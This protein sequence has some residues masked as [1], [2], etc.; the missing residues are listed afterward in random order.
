MK[1]LYFTTEDLN[2]GLFH[3][4]VFG[5]LKAVRESQ[6]KF[7]ITILVINQP[8]K[9]KSHINVLELLKKECI[10]VIYIPLLPPM[11]WFTS[12]FFISNI[13]LIYLTT[14]SYLF[15]NLKKY[16][17]IHCRHYLTSLV[18]IKLRYNNFLFDVR[19]L[20][21]FEYIQAKKI[22]INSATYNYWLNF[23]RLI[24][25]N[26]AAV[27]VVSKTM[28]PYFESIHKRKY[29]FCPII[30]D[31]N[32]IKYCLSSRLLIRNQLKWNDKR[33]YVY[34]GSFGLYGLNKE[35][36]AKMVNFII[37][38][39]INSRF[40][41]LVSN[42]KNEVEHFLSV[43]NFD[44][45]IFHIK[46]TSYSNMY[47]YL[48]AAD[49]GIHSLPNQIDGFSRLGTKIIEYWASGLPVIINNNIGEAA[50]IC[51]EHN[52]GEV[53]NF[54]LNQGDF[55]LILTELNKSDR[56]KIIIDSE[57]LFSSYCIAQKYINIYTN[58][59]ENK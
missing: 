39:D 11:R 41:F 43:N 3:S 38:Y 52:F 47:R 5:L 21:V 22:K 33:I 36:L 26:A 50:R 32:V 49:I 46:N 27:S 14:I 25:Q 13:Y 4:Q 55:E 30:A 40:L 8:W 20:H 9:F 53:I 42:H 34:S 29:N 7:Q 57:K 15:V 54:N 24:I 35:Y 56:Y 16:D 2:S 17:F 45:K 59:L 1:L 48:S 44:S 31:F 18:L 6:K 28:I 58:F 51:K 37:K 10:E 19:S 23:E 12:N